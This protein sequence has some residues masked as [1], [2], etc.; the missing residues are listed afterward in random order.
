MGDIKRPHTKKV[1]FVGFALCGHC[2]GPITT[3][4]HLKKQKNGVQRTYVYYR[5]T[6]WRS[7]GKVCDGSHISERDLV[8]Q[9]GE[10]LK[11]FKIDVPTLAKIKSALRE[12]AAG[13]RAYNTDR[14][15]ALRSEET[16]L[17]IWIDKAYADRLDDLLTVDEYRKKVASW[18]GRL[19]EIQNEMRAALPLQSGRRGKN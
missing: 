3:E 4:T 1:A 19:M 10:P 14:I 18:R 16:R 2:G 13:E 9:L 7:K 12:S 6:G 8:A 15:T 11:N 17:Q 5:C